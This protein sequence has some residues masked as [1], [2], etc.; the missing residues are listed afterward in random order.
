MPMAALAAVGIVPRPLH[1]L[2]CFARDSE[3]KPSACHLI[4]QFDFRSRCSGLPDLV[5]DCPRA[6]LEMNP[7]TLEQSKFCAFQIE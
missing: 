7:H 2:F 3:F 4:F 1:I 6:V 5:Y